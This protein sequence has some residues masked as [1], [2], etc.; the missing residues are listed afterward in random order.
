MAVLSRREGMSLVFLSAG[1]AAGKSVAQFPVIRPRAGRDV[2]RGKSGAVVDFCRLAKIHAPP[3]PVRSTPCR[4]LLCKPR[5]RPPALLRRGSHSH[6]AT[7]FPALLPA[8]VLMA[9]SIV[10]FLSLTSSLSFCRQSGK[11]T[12]S[13]LD[14]SLW[15]MTEWERISLISCPL[16]LVI[17]SSWK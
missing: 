14:H 3:D 10:L 12:S 5:D 11:D 6:G 17:F 15:I 16:F 8:D 1:S 13:L 2:A 4:A 9:L 7:P